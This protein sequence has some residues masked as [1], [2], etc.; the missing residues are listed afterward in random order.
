MFRISRPR[1]GHIR[2]TLLID[3]RLAARN[4]LRQRRRSLISLAAIGFGIISMMQAAGYIEWIFWATREGVAVT[5]LGHIQVTQRGY[6]ENGRADPFAFLLPDDQRALEA[7][8]QAPD[9][10]SV[11]PRLS[12]NGLISHGEGTLSFIGEGIDPELDPATRYMIVVEG[13]LPSRDDPR[14][15]LLGSGL[16]ANLGVKSGDTVVLMANTTAGGINAVEGKVRG[17]VSTS[18]KAYDD[19]MLRINI[20]LARELLRTAGAHVWVVSLNDTD[21]TE[22]AL[23][24]VVRNATLKPYEIAPWMRL[25]DFYNKTVELLSLQIGVVE[26]IIGTIIILSIGNTMTMSVLERTL[27]IGTAMALGVRRSRILG[28]FMLEGM[29]LGAIGGTVGVILGYVIA[30]IVSYVGIPMPPGPGMSRGFTAGIII[31]PSIVLDALL[32]AF[33]TALLASIYPAWRASRLNIVDALRHT[34]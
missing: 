9:V 17:L 11:T 3:L 27:E 15:I 23:R 20:D 5:Q 19:S 21:M 10:R 14:G 30:G 1:A 16:A 26:L 33:A 6:H 28:M 32:L 2:N 31:T 29:L 22:T 4:I 12:F 25:A 13:S 34:R 18:M 8:R 7:L 24:N